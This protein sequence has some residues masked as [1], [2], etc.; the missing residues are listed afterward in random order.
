MKY[1]NNKSPGFTIVELLIVIVVIG[2][3]A[4]MTIVAFNG[5]QER[6]R[7]SSAKAFAAQLEKKHLMD[8]EGLWSFNECSGNS[9]SNRSDK[10]TSDV[11]GTLA[12]STDT[13]SGSGCAAQFNG[14]TRIR[15]SADLSAGGSSYDYYLKAAWVKVSSCA[16]NNVISSPD[17]ING[18]DSP[19][20][21]P[22][23]TVRAGH[24]GTYSRI[25]SDETLKLNTWHHI[26]T[27]FDNGTYRL[28]IDGKRVKETS[29]HPLLTAAATGVNIGAH[30]T[31]SSFTGLMDDAL[32]VS[33]RFQ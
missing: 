15:T 26:A 7:L 32:I 19:F 6:A 23:C 33:K 21:L 18:Q 12:W 2:I 25:I 28:Y 10:A 8:A 16:N 22:N 9:V 29:G 30:R 5:I 4:A 13:P 14:S 17:D 20:W 27:E 1:Y 31:G 3:L 11:A 24:N